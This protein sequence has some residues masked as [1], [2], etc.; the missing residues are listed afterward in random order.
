MRRT[1]IRQTPTPRNAVVQA[2][3][4]HTKLRCELACVATLLIAYSVFA[5][6]TLWW[7]FH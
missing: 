6:T 4:D 3:S 5:A 7:L 1:Y 2:L